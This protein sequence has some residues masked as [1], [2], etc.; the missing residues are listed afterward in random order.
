MTAA[1]ASAAPYGAEYVTTL[2]CDSPN[3]WPGAPLRIR[4]DVYTGAPFPSDGLVG[5][6]IS[7]SAMNRGGTGPILEVTTLTTVRWTNRTSGRSG[8]VRVPTRAHSASW[9]AVLHPGRGRVAF[10]IHQKIGALAFVPMV[11]P[12][13]SSCRG[14]VTL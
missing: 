3:P 13:Y 12:Q 2:R 6:A 5:P 9:D 1:P 10:T 8:V 7:L 4:V 14:S 11:N